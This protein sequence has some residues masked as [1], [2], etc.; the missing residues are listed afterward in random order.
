[1][2]SIVVNAKYRNSRK[3]YYELMAR[4]VRMGYPNTFYHVLSR[5]NERRNIFRDAQEGP[6]AK[7]KNWPIIKESYRSR[8]HRFR[9]HRQSEPLI[10][11]F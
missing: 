2:I 8:V 4:P 1:M 11:E 10:R 3:R 5:G 6:W 7:N 9:V